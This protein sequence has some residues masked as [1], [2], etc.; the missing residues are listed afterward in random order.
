MNYQIHSNQAAIVQAFHEHFELSEVRRFSEGGTTVMIATFKL[1]ALRAQSEASDADGYRFLNS[2]DCRVVIG[3]R[4]VNFEKICS[5]NN[6]S[7][8]EVSS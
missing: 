4:S 7:R 8:E 2:S 5:G 1:R 3:R 6:Y